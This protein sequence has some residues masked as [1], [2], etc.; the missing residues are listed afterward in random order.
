M[1]LNFLIQETEMSLTLLILGIIIFIC[2]LLN[3]ASTKIGVPVLLA[4][5]VFGIFCGNISA[6]PVYLDNYGVAEN[7]CTGALVFIMFYGGFGTRWR[8]ARKVVTESALLA[9][10]GV[11][12][13]ALLAGLICRLIF[14]WGWLECFLLG[15]VISSTDAASVFSI[16]RGSKMALKNNT[17]S[18][19][20]VE[21][22]SNDPCSYLMTIL[23]LSLMKGDMAGWQAV[24]LVINQIAI[25]AL[26]G[27]VIAVVGVRLMR[28]IHFLKE[29]FDSIM[30]VSIA[31]ISYSL[32]AVF[33]GNGFLS[34]YIVG[35]IMGN[36]VFPGKV[37]LTGFFDGV[38]SLMQLII[39]FM[40]GLLARPEG[41][42]K[43]FLP[44]LAVFA[45]ILI[46]V[47]PAAT[48]A[49][50]TPFRRYPWRQQLL[51]SFAGLRGASSI[52]FAIVAVSGAPELHIDI[53]NMVFC[54][55]LMSITLQGCLLPYAAKGLR[56]VDES[57]DAHKSFEDITQETD[58]QFSKVE[59]FPGGPW[60]GK[61][62]RN[63][64]LPK[65]LL[66]CR[67]ES[68][69][70]TKVPNGNT[71]LHAGDKVII[72]AMPYH[73]QKEMHII[74]E[75]VRKGSPMAGRMIKEHINRKNNEQVVLLMRNDEYLIPTGSTV[76][77]VGDVIFIN[78][79]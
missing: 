67:V 74:Q 61:A 49:V 27:Y 45:V 14:R 62:I 58:L 7:I 65:T 3:S 44:A 75:V 46:I 12:L 55:V 22:G 26:G 32:P 38:T 17:S 18:V 66:V 13:T 54:I 20:E 6:I 77:E 64:N 68:E 60:D 11:I 43:A 19:L 23:F 21:S 50:L 25:G 79:L 30:V 57:P 5:I 47:R 29:G 15:S 71:V 36:S 52:V 59:V 31:L 41:L 56:M 70:G 73:S 76:L 8:S 78:K 2:V 9:T 53:F 4:F 24:L 28:R 40:L 39:F 33:G 69:D 16:M 10:V 42:S 72:C 63:L 48:A 34:A 35:M 51:I 37:K 1:L